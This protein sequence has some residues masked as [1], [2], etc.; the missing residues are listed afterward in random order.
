MTVVL[1]LVVVVVVAYLLIS[2]YSDQ[3]R[4]SQQFAWGLFCYHVLF[5][6]VYYLYALAKPS[7][8]KA[9]YRIGSNGVP[10]HLFGA[11][12]ESVGWIDFYGFGTTFIDFLVYPFV[13]LLGFSYE[14]AML[15][16]SVFG[17]VG[18][19][20][21]YL[22][23]A[24]RTVYRHKFFG[25]DVV[26]L[27]FF[28]P[29]AHFYSASLGKGSVILAGMGMLFYGLNNMRE[30]LPVLLIGALIVLHIRPHVMGALMAS[31]V[32]GAIISNKGLKL[33]QKVA[34]VGISAFGAVPL[35]EVAFGSAGI[36]SLDVEEVLS[37]ADKRATDH[38][39][40]NSAV[41]IQNYSQPMI[42]FTF[43]FRPLFVDSPNAMGLIVSCEN[44][45]YL[46]LFIKIISLRFVKYFVQSPWMVKTS[47]IAFIVISLALAQFS[48][49]LGLATRQK[50]QVTYLFFIVLLSYADY[51]YRQE[52]KVVI[53][54]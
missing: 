35:L 51:S 43:L 31:A 1:A 17:F 49:N 25:I 53:G 45:L 18:F 3:V 40:A 37:A 46:I 19:F 24:E 30:R 47:F 36:E 21:F 4:H 52:R 26:V 2:A 5:A 10:R 28:F 22:L 15:L 20:F 48:S 44:L 41:D 23:L 8:S 54:E 34:I 50:T 39:S 29:I 12:P 11:D 6:V 16:F 9:Y 33:W 38:L 14:A 27:I 32:V 7:D 13:Y 42:L